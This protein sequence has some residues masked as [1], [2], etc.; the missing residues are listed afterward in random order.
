MKNFFSK[1]TSGLREKLEK[2]RQ[3]LNTPVSDLVRQHIKVD[4]FFIEEL[5]EILIQADVGVNTTMTIIERIDERIKRDKIKATSDIPPILYEEIAAILSS[6]EGHLDITPAKPHVIMMV[7]VNGTGKTTTIGK[8]AQRFREEGQ[9]VMLAACDTFRAAAIEQLDIW[10]QRA[11]VEITKNKQNT[12]PASVA[13]DALKAAKSRQ[14]DILIVDTAGRLHTNVNLMEELKKIRR[15][16]R[17]TNP[18]APHEILLTL[19][20]TTG[21]NALQQARIFNDALDLTGLV[22]TKLD[23]TAKGGIVVAIK[24]EL[25]VPIKLIG[26]GE[27]IEDL[28]DFSARDFAEALFG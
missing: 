13:F 28:R 24:Q 19:D 14:M 21:Q 26:V 22:I 9:K 11:K 20:A 12:D 7:G 27:K 17:K 1:V 3:V 18:D 15:V 23:G 10:A 8:M 2:T 6:E 5:E 16:L 25:D 4:D